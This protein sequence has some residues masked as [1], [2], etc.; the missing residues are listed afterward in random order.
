MILEGNVAH[1]RCADVVFVTCWNWHADRPLN[2]EIA[3][4]LSSGKSGRNDPG[5]I[6]EGGDSG[7]RLNSEKSADDIVSVL[8]IGADQPL[9]DG[10]ERPIAES[11]RGFDQCALEKRR[12]VDCLLF[13]FQTFVF[14]RTEA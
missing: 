7:W 1:D 6:G 9:F 3:P 11:R 10:E 12:N 5:M 8:F 13:G 14:R 4:S 2:I